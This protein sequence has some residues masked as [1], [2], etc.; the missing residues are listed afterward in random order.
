MLTGLAD[1]VGGRTAAHE[2]GE[3]GK[4]EEVREVHS[5]GRQWE[6]GMRSLNWVLSRERKSAAE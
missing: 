5:Y 4:N 2:A 6:L 1:A 3:R